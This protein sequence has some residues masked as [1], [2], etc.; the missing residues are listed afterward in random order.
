MRIGPSTEEALQ[1]AAD[2]K[3]GV[4]IYPHAFVS[5]H[6]ETLVEIDMEY[7]HMAQDMGVPW[8]GK[9]ETVGTNPLFIAGLAATV[10]AQDNEKFLP[11]QCAA[12]ARQCICK[13]AA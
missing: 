9:A 3:V 2:D 7:R 8:F 4:L 12:K 5:E 13:K 11:G 1:K 10:Q 6:V